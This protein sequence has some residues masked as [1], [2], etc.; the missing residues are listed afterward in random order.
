METKFDTL[1][2]TSMCFVGKFHFFV[3]V[4]KN[5][6]SFFHKNS[7]LLF[8]WLIYLFFGQDM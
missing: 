7:I 4:K 6:Y 3:Y 5:W 8:M 1:W 2:G